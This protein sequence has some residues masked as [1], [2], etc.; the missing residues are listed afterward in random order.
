ME[1]PSSQTTSASEIPRTAQTTQDLSLPGIE[2]SVFS[3]FTLA[4]IIFSVCVWVLLWSRNQVQQTK[5]ALSQAQHQL[6]RAVKEQ[7]LLELELNMILSPASIEH[8]VQ[9]WNLQPAS[10]VIDIYENGSQ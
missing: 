9:E 10:T 2:V 5:V 7:Q 3:K 4:L 1:S 8:Q 6:D